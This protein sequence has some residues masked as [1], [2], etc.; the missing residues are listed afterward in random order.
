MTQKE[1]L[2]I[3]KLGHTTYLTG[4]A[5]SGK[6]HVLRSYI[7]YLRKCGI[8]VAVTASTGIAATHLGGQ[9]IHSWS[10]IGV[11]DELTPFDLDELE[12]RRGL[13]KRYENTHVLIIDEVSMLAA[14]QLDMVDRIARHMKRTDRPFGGMQVV[15]SGDFFQLPPV[16][17]GEVRYA[18]ESRVWTEAPPVVCYLETQYRQKDPAFYNV[19]NDVRSRNVTGKTRSYLES[20]LNISPDEHIEIT[21]LFTHNA[22]VDEI[23]ER[24]LT[25]LD[26]EEYTFEMT[27]RG[28]KKLVGT[29]KNG[30][31]A[32]EALR[33]K[34]GAAVMFVKNDPKGAFVNGTLGRVVDIE[35]GMPVV[36]CNDK[37][38][39]TA[40]PMSWKFEDGGDVRAEVTQVPLRLAWAITVHKSQGM[41]LDAAEMDLSKTFVPG[42]GYVALSRVKGLKSIFLKGLNDQAL[43]VDPRVAF[44][45]KALKQRSEIARARYQEL[46]HD[47]IRDKQAHF[48]EDR[49][50]AIDGSKDA[51]ASRSAARIPTVDKTKALLSEGSLASIAKERGL[52]EATII[53]HI[54]QLAERGDVLDIDHLR[55]T[56]DRFEV[57]IEAFRESSETKLTPIKRILEKR[58]ISVTYRELECARAFATYEA[59]RSAEAPEV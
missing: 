57:M 21:R 29:L 55:P 15:F 39:V 12:G 33:L 35:H 48:V 40:E 51:R 34:V 1:A 32:P 50:G 46:S 6:T 36:E 43:E 30:C 2:D 11:K 7:S 4:P 44:A 58:G 8:E 45:D 59:S 16:R 14:E 3:L 37:S 38:K 24:E 54:Q 49:G 17:R 18:Y 41:T 5:G 13:W 53:K 27:S 23:N 26:T 19:L 20:R 10:G 56:G 52:T 47:A 9:T 42:Q 31:L 22:D 25:R 28:P